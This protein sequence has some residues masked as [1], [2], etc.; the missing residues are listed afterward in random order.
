MSDNQ[1]V[2]RAAEQQ[3]EL[4]SRP[5]WKRFLQTWWKVVRE[6]RKRNLLLALLIP[7]VFTIG[8][9]VLSNEQSEG[10]KTAFNWLIGALGAYLGLL[11]AISI[12]KAFW[13]IRT[14]DTY[15]VGIFQGLV[16]SLSVPP[17]TSPL[18][19]EPPPEFSIDKR[20]QLVGVTKSQQLLVKLNDPALPSVR[21][22]TLEFRFTPAVGVK[23]SVQLEAS[24]Q[25]N[26]NSFV[27]GFWLES[28]K[29]KATL[30]AG[31]SDQLILAVRQNDSFFR[32]SVRR[33]QTNLRQ[34]IPVGEL[35]LLPDDSEFLVEFLFKRN[36]KIIQTGTAKLRLFQDVGVVMFGFTMDSALN[37]GGLMLKSKT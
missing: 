13:T 3:L 4:L 14:E 19:I 7:A 28:W 24:V 16:K 15:A 35:S 17:V 2:T 36:Q 9:V 6:M 27:K 12:V 30:S 31:D 5:Y 21:A 34:T 32:Y 22:Y 10:A 20:E 8:A 33:Q 37:D 11:W 26:G 25:I 18:D 29:D 23:G 1:I